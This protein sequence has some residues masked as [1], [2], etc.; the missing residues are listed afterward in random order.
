[1]TNT[2]TTEIVKDVSEAVMHKRIVRAIFKGTRYPSVSGFVTTEDLVHMSLRRLGNIVNSLHEKILENTSKPTLVVGHDEVST[3]E[4][5]QL[6]EKFDVSLFIHK[7]RTAEMEAL[8]EEKKN[9]AKETESRNRLI[10]QAKRALAL[11]QEREM[12]G[13]TTEQLQ[14]IVDQG[15]V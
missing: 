11:K 4:Q 7:T 12:E 6:K 13:Y 10:A 5:E 9:R 2:S 3:A 15:G 14:A 1:M 8:A